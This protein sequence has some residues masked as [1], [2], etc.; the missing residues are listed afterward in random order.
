[1]EAGGCCYIY[2]IVIDGGT[3]YYPDESLYH[4]MRDSRFGLPRW[5]TTESIHPSILC[6]GQFIVTLEFETLWNPLTLEQ[7]AKVQF[8]G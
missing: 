1:M 8:V 2:R 4:E 7:V 3:A 5:L 6:E